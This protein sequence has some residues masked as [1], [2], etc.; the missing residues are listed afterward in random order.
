MNESYLLNKIE[1]LENRIEILEKEIKE[2]KV[3]TKNYNNH[4]L[5]IFGPI[6]LDINSVCT[7]VNIEEH[8][9][10]C[11]NKLCE[12]CN[13]TGKIQG[14]LTTYDCECIKKE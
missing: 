9:N 2:L 6:K 10:K 11:K 14:F 8:L 7:C 5:P 4:M 12:K 13:G 3:C 1:S